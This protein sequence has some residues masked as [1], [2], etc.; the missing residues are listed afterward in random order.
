M[1]QWG[2]VE[3]K[4]NAAHHLADV[5]LREIGVGAARAACGTVEARFDTAQERVTI[6]ACRLWMQLIMS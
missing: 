3:A 5:V 1:R 4:A 6:N 2:A